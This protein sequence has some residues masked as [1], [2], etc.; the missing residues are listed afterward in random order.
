MCMSKKC[1]I[2]EVEERLRTRCEEDRMHKIK[3]LLKMQ[4]KNK[5]SCEFWKTER[6]VA[7]LRN[8]EEKIRLKLDLKERE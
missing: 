5:Q 4:L 7:K 2:R 6:Q 1:S 8:L 3:Q